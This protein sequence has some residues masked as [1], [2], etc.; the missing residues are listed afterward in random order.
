M[1]LKGMLVLAD[2]LTGAADT[3]VAL[4]GV[5]G[6]ADVDLDGHTLPRADQ[7]PNVLALDLHTRGLPEVDAVGRVM[8]AT[9]ALRISG[10]S[11]YKKIDS[12]WRGHIGAELAAMSQVLG[13]GVVYVVAAAHPDLGRTV[14]GGRLYVH[15]VAVNRPPVSEDLLAHGF[16]VSPAAASLD[17]CVRWA[18]AADRSGRTAIACDAATMI[19]LR[20]VVEAAA[21]LGERV[22]WVGS[23]GL[24][25]ALADMA[26]TDDAAEASNGPAKTPSEQ[27]QVPDLPP[28]GGRLLVVGSHAPIA[29]AQV[30][31]LA[32]HGGVTVIDLPIGSLSESGEDEVIASQIEQAWLRNNDVVLRPAP[33][34]PVLSSNARTVVEGLARLAAPHI[35]RA[36]GLVVCGGDT[37]RSLFDRAGLRRLRVR[38][39]SEVG[40]VLGSAASHPGLPLAL[41]AGAF[42]DAG[43]LARLCGG[44]RKRAA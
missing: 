14:M 20:R 2:D 31:A 7:A 23:G 9:C 37:A 26:P 29:R 22:V 30:D 38:A 10:R 33:A 44:V 1:P 41:K 12:T 13:P 4:A 34:M 21:P 40:T 16:E 3:A 8:Q 32:A 11:V 5:G 15:G 36:R 25:L 18:A 6:F 28:L 24:A 42:G 43:L 17:E 39:W 27:E 35:D 19:D